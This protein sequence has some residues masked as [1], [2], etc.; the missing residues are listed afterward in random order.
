M[1]IKPIIIPFLFMI[2]TSCNQNKPTINKESAFVTKEEK[3]QD[4]FINKKLESMDSI[5][6]D[7]KERSEKQIVFI[8]TGFDCQSCVDKVYNILKTLRSLDNSQEIFVISYN[9][10]IGT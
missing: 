4:R 5:I 7:K 6:F 2:M 10:N 1:I 3:L 8:Y 9:T